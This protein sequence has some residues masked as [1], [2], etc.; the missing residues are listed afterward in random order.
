M[1]FAKLKSFFIAVV[2]FGWLIGFFIKQNDEDDISA[3][4]EVVDSEKAFDYV[5]VFEYDKES[6]FLWTE[7][8]RTYLKYSLTRVGLVLE[9]RTIIRTNAGKTTVNTELISCCKNPFKLK[10]HKIDKLV[11]FYLLQPCS[12][13]N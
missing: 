13:K 5:I 1:F 6:D 4:I 3:E 9:E 2:T 7:E 11:V 8:I 12:R 10:E